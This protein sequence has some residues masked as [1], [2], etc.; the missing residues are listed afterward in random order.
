MNNIL[1]GIIVA[2]VLLIIIGIVVY[3]LTP[4]KR[5]D[6]DDDFMRMALAKKAASNQQF[7][8]EQQQ[9]DAIDAARA[10]AAQKI[11]TDADARI[12]QMEIDKAAWEAANAPP[13]VCSFKYPIDNQYYTI[14]DDPTKATQLMK[15][16]LQS[17]SQTTCVAMNSANGQGCP[18]KNCFEWQNKTFATPPKDTIRDAQ[19]MASSSGF[20]SE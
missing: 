3:V 20:F 8:L 9:Q 14:D 16:F 13:F 7:A 11:V 12:A 10:A 4:A 18:N 5:T 1:I 19:R 2:I 15:N 17:P 6:A